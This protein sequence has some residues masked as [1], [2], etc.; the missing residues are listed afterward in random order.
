MQTPEALFS[1]ASQ[2]ARQFGGDPDRLRLLHASVGLV[3]ETVRAER[4]L[5]LKLNRCG[6]EGSRELEGRLAWIRHLR[7][8]GMRVPE[9]LP[10]RAGRF[11]EEIESGDERFSAYAY[12]KIDLGPANEIRWAENPGLP[13]KLGAAMGKMHRLAQDAPPEIRSVI[14]PWDAADWIDRPEQVIH[15]SQ[16]AIIEAIRQLRAEIRRF[17][18]TGATF[19][20]I[21][22]DL[23]TANVYTLDGELLIL[24]FDQLHAS[25]F[26]ADIASTLLFRVWIGPDKE[27]PPIQAAG[28]EFLRELTRGY[29]AENELPPAW[30]TMLPFFL[31]LREIS[32]F[33]SF[34]RTTPLEQ[35]LRDPFFAYIYASIGSNRPFLPGI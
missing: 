34:F 10:S 24:D 11:V 12:P 18:Q 8:N 4:P 32:L 13:C 22:D 19:G 9:L 17:P 7:A 25:W 30:E 35:G 16:A 15:P 20:L 2:L 21:H 27:K 5:I 23:H 33:Q 14:G 26:A 3:Y 1:A 31:K 6:P 29:Q 28:M